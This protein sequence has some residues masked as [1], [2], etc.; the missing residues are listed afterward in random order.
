MLNWTLLEVNHPTTW[1]FQKL[2]TLF[3][4]ASPL[5]PLFAVP[6]SENAWQ[7]DKFPGWLENLNNAWK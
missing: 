2:K 5:Q 4:V 6:W 1:F 7:Q 3:K